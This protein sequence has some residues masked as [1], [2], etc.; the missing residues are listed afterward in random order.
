MV[1]EEYYIIVIRMKH[2]PLPKTTSK[3]KQSPTKG[4]VDI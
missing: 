2:R 3:A 4:P 1:V